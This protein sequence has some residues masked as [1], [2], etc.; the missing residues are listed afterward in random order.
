M[1][2]INPRLSTLV[3]GY[4]NPGRQDDGLGPAFIALFQPYANEQCVLQTGYQLTVEHALDLTH[5]E[6]IIFVDACIAGSTPFQLEE[7][8]LDNLPEFGSH[9]LSPHAVL[10]LTHTLYQH[11]PKAFI[12]A[13]Q[14]DA[15]DEFEEQLSSI[16]QHNLVLAKNFLAG[17][18]NA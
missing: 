6:Q 14:G 2:H 18:F 12:L 9:H 4:G 11:T 5:Y 16:A 15:F 7:I 8:T 17:Q 10:Q 3:I 1:S 13:I